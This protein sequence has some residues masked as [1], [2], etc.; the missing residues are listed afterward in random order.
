[1]P[2]WLAQDME[3]FAAAAFVEDELQV[4]VKDAN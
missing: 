1:V 4:D 3:Q 2:P